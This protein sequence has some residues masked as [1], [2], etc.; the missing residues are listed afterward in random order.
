MFI[1]DAHLDLSMN[2]LEWNRDLKKPLSEINER[3]KGLADKPDRGRATVSLPE[4]RKGN[5]G[6]VV[7]TQI[8]RYVAPGNPL[9]GWHSPE[10]AWAHTQGQLAWY[11]TMEEEGEMIQVNNVLTLEKHLALWKNEEP[12]E[13]K[14]VGYILSLEGADSL[15]TT[16]YLEK[17]Y[18]YGLRAVG[19]AH[20]GAGRYAQG[21]DATGFMGERGRA[22]LK[23]MERLNIILDATHLC[24]DSFWEAMDHF[25]GPVWASHNNVRT[26]VNHNRQFSD[27]QIKELIQR[28][29]VIGGVLDAWMMV[30]S[31]VRGKSTPQAMNCK[32]EVLIDH[33]DHICQLAG[34]VLHIGIGSDLDGGFGKEQCP[35]DLETI[36]DL[37]K[38]PQLFTRRGYSQ[39]D[40]EN[41]MHGNWLRFLK[42][43]WKNK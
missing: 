19:P 34:N 16:E 43:A 31:W 11:K 10:Q 26:L 12:S 38:L 25:N 3:E 17:A 8:A 27:E 30:P 9:P 36:A 40:I 24:D 6:L 41:I 5:I 22:L 15:I 1:I 37:Q 35:Y 7:A 4:L 13:H 14:P 33:L 21:T 20:Y 28:G 23:E 29:A 32:L 18:Q 2:A 39:S 42:N